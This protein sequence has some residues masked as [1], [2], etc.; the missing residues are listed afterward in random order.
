MK[1]G[2]F[3]FMQMSLFIIFIMSY[4]KI[5]LSNNIFYLKVKFQIGEMMI[6]IIFKFINY[7]IGLGINVFFLF[8]INLQYMIIIFFFKNNFYK[9]EIINKLFSKNDLLNRIEIIF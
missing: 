6:N 8:F 2:V 4:F 3:L 1:N 7:Y 9:E 5:G